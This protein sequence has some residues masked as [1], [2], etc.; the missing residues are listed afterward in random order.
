MLAVETATE[1]TALIQTP[2][3]EEPLRVQQAQQTLVL[4]QEQATTMLAVQALSSFHTQ[5]YMRLQQLQ[6]VHQL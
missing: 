5:T 3:E 6:Q 2:L 1:I 4:E